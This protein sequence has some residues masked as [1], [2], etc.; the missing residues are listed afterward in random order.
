M[1]IQENPTRM[2]QEDPIELKKI[3]AW[4][5]KKQTQMALISRLVKVL[6]D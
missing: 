2:I 6:I 4:S 3:M 5:K 1:M